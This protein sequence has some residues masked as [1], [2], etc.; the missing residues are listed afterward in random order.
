[1]AKSS[2]RSARSFERTARASPVQSRSPR[3][4]VIPRKTRI[5]LQVTGIAAESAIHSG[6]SGNERMISI[7]RWTTLSTQPP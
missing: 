5:G 7:E 1:M 2:S 6:N 4:T 3:I